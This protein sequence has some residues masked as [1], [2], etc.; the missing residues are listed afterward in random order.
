[1]K[2]IILGFV[3]V[4]VLVF[5]IIQVIP[6]HAI[7]E[8]FADPENPALIQEI[9]WPDSKTESIARRACYDCHSNETKYPFYASI[10]PLKWLLNRHINIGR[11][12]LNFSDF[13]PSDVDIDDF[14]WHVHNNMPLPEY[15]LLHP[16]A[17]L[18]EEEK[19]QLITVMQEIA[20]A[21]DSEGHNMDDET[22]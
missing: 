8:T 4:S 9:N 19:E 21:S 14:I 2:K 18:T 11:E 20:P 5:A 1:M 22:D 6:S 16:E 17:A 15:V 3:L 12:V 7:H 13:R 10:A